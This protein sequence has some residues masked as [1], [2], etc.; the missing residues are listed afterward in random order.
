[1]NPVNPL[2]LGGQDAKEFGTH[3]A[4]ILGYDAAGVVVQRGAKV[5]RLQAGDAV[6][7]YLLMGADVAIDYTRTRFEEVAKDVDVVVDPIGRDTLARSYPVVKRGGIIVT[8]VSRCDPAELEKY[9]IRSESLFSHPSADDL[10]EITKLID[11]DKIKPIVTEILPFAQAAKATQQAET[12]HTRGKV[13]LQ[14][15]TNRRSR[16]RPRSAPATYPRSR[17]S[18]SPRC[19]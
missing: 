13:V 7:A 4:L 18:Y 8:L 16:N 11:A 2:I 9:G 5:T 14:S 17:R 12:H 15:P 3:L 10:A 1:M 6:Y 19:P